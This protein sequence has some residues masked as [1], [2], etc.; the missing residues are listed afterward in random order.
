[1]NRKS[2]FGLLQSGFIFW[3]LAGG[4]WGWSFPEN[5]AS[6]AG[7]I[8]EALMLIMLGM[9]LTLKISDIR[10]LRHAGRP[11]LV[12][13]S[14]QYLIMPLAAWSLSMALNLSPMLAM[15]VILVGCS[16]GGT[17]SNVV[18]WLA[19]GDVALSVAMTSLSTLLA[20][21]MTPLWVWLLASAWID[22]DPAALF[23]SVVQIVLL[24]VVAGIAIRSLWKP[25]KILLNGVFPLVA[26]LTIA[27]IVGVVVGLN[28]GRLHD[29]ATA[30]LLSVVL[31]N[32]TGLLLGRF[33]M[34]RLGYGRRKSRTVA[35]EVGMQNSGLAVA[36]AMAHF[37]PE[38]ALAGALFSL[39]HNVSGA[40]LADY[41]RKSGGKKKQDDLTH[42]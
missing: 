22:I 27:W 10:Q 31:L 8:K 9:G 39:W 1:M 13:V 29:V 20:P 4:L 34:Q 24:P 2:L 7:W 16:P 3:V 19:R 23:V 41:W 42:I 18:S 28:I 36:L 6:G 5:A 33:V 14:L 15:G 17:A 30:L 25:G 35:I 12:G 21:I 40:L 11:L 38:A 37:S 26:M 32:V